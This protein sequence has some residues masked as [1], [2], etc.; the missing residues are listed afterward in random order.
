MTTDQSESLVEQ[1]AAAM[2]LEKSSKERGGRGPR[3]A[4]ASERGRDE[5]VGNAK[6][7]AKN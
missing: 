1:G 6:P 3:S 7:S 4:S 5:R 2:E